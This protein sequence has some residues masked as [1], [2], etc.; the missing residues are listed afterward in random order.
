[1]KN[2]QALLIVDVQNDFCPGGSLA[3][4]EGDTVIPMLNKYIKLFSRRGFPVFASRDWHPAE[5][6]HFKKFGG[7]WPEHC[8]QGTKGAEFHQDL[9]L[10]GNTFIVL[11]GM[12]FGSD[13][14]SVFQAEDQKGVK[15]DELLKKHE[16]QEVFIGGLATDFCVKASVIG[17]LDKGFK[18]YLLM[19]AVKGVNLF[20]P[21]DSD[22]AIGEMVRK[23]ARKT[24]LLEVIDLVDGF[25]D[26]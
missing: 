18:V 4:P 13:G 24:N 2:N 17:A 20:S 26:V 9:N 1:M 14:Y 6:S 8:I 10:P 5:T 22:K 11:K 21:D 15:F 19:D 23:G 16:I 7:Q 3:V 25:L 12:D